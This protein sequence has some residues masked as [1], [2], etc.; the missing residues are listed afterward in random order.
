MGRI[1]I[2]DDS[3]TVRLKI[4]KAVE[5]LGHEAVAVPDGIVALKTLE[6]AQFDTVLLDIMMPEM[7]G[8]EVLETMKANA[9][10][11]DIPVI[12]ISALSDTMTSVVKA[13]E[14][15]AEDFL[16]KSFDLSLLKSRLSASI[17]K[18][19]KRSAPSEV[20]VRAA[21]VDDI[22]MLLSF[23]NT[24]GAGMPLEAWKLTCR[25][26]QSPWDKG[27]EIML[28]TETD[29]YFGNCWIAETAS[30][31]LGGLVLYVPPK[32]SSQDSDVVLDFM[33]PLE[34]LETLAEGTVYVSYLCTI[35]SYRGQGIGSALLKFAERQK[36]P[37]GMSIVVSSANSG[38]RALYQ[39]F[40][41]NET[42]RRP[43]IMPDGQRN[44]HDWILMVKK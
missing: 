6:D 22:P 30:G 31:G 18:S 13:M 41:Y 43:M 14:L 3:S 33:A 44:G 23:V 38:A 7:D 20:P 24:A 9:R 4:R 11:K 10:T 35:D 34:E 2:V 40:G 39:R 37:N 12:V 28:D 32:S 19:L 15:G 26:G 29:I 16:P 42:T 27:R 25:E 17:E 1:L 8:F 5:N 21:T 36:G